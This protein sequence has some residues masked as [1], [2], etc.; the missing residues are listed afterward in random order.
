VL[1]QI[2]NTIIVFEQEIK[3]RLSRFVPKQKIAV[4]CLSVDQQKVVQNLLL[5]KNLAYQKT[6]LFY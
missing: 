5:E 3:D 2:A 6:S 1:G 4:L